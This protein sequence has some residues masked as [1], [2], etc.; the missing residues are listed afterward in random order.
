M[1]LFVAIVAHLIV[2]LGIVFVPHDNP[3]S[4]RST[5]DIIL[6]QQRSENAPEEADYLAQANQEGGGEHTE[7]ARPATPLQAPLSGP[8]PNVIAAAPPAEAVDPAPDL[9]NS[10]RCRV[11]VS[12]SGQRRKPL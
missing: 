7:K 12:V 9:E 2:I 5:L 4:L 3:D 11:F 8:E 1:T 6:V 10:G